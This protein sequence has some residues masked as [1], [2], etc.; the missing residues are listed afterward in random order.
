MRTLSLKCGLAFL[1]ITAAIIMC[2][3]SQK[4]VSS[5]S[6]TNDSDNPPLEVAYEYSLLNLVH[7]HYTEGT[8][9]PDV[10]PDFQGKGIKGFRDWFLGR[11]EYPKEARQNR[12]TGK[13]VF[14]FVVD[15]DG[16]VKDVRIISS[17]HKI[18]SQGVLSIIYSSPQWTPAE[19]NGEKVRVRFSM[20]TAFDI[21]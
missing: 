5:R 2:A 6:G 15:T 14:S 19:D 7:N 10:M 9:F 20:L 13:V 12:I 18:L 8:T 17:P 4:T 16:R 1:Y 3:C 11:V 21:Y